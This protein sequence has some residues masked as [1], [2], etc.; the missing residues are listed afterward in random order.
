VADSV[1]DVLRTARQTLATAQ[2]G[3]SG[4]TGTDPTRR[5]TGIYN[6]AVFGRAVTLV[7]QKI[8]GIDRAAFDA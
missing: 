1:H 3:L 8:R 4:L 7:L 5:V 2:R 6:V